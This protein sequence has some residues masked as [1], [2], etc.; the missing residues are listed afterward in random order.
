[1]HK[2]VSEFKSQVEQLHPKIIAIT[3]SWCHDG[4]N[5]AEVWITFFAR[6]DIM[7]EQ[8]GYYYMFTNFYH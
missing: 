7:E 3:E 2:Q 6:I 1:M 8:E 4:I 5:N